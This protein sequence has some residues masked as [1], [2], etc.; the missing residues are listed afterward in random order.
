MSHIDAVQCTLYAVITD[1]ESNIVHSDCHQLELNRA[2][3]I[4]K[5]LY[6]L[7]NFGRIRYAV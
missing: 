6:K 4:R 5:K 7:T 3:K 1:A 2:V